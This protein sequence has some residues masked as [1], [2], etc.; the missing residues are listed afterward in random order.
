MSEC[1]RER[2]KESVLALSKGEGLERQRDPWLYQKVKG[3]AMWAGCNEDGPTRVMH[4]CNKIEVGMLGQTWS[5]RVG[6]DG[7]VIQSVDLQP[8]F[9]FC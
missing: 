9:K 7:L 4:I 5:T 3:F 8:N 6:E 2:E 1:E